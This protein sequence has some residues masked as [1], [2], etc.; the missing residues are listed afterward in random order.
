MIVAGVGF[1][2][3]ATAAAIAE[4]VALASVRAGCRPQ[5]IAA[6]ADKA[7]APALHAASGGLPVVAVPPAAMAAAGTVTQSP[8]V[9]ALRGVG[10]VA[11]AAALAAAG[12]GARLLGPRAVSGCGTA[13]AALAEG[14]P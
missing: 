2:A 14:G 9:R 4:A 11:E 8:R 13:T 12:P 7:A 10:S 3:A 5:A 1:R 6:P